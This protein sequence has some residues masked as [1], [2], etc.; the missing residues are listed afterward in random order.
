M[1]EE[2]P[3]FGKDFAIEGR[4]TIVVSKATFNRNAE[5]G[6][7]ALFAAKY[8]IYRRG[9]QLVQPIVDTV[10][11][12]DG[13]MTMT[14]VLAP[15]TVPLMRQWLN[16]VADWVKPDG[17]S[18]RMMPVAPPPEVAEL[19]LHRAGYWPFHSIAGVITTPTMRP[20]GTLLTVPS[21]DEMTRLRLFGGTTM[22]PIP[23]HPT[24]EDAQRAL[25]LLKTL[26]GGFPFVDEVSEAVALSGFITPVVRGVMPVAPMHVASAPKSGTGKSYLWDIASCIAV[27]KP[28]AVIAAGR[29]EAE[30]EKRLVA[31]VLRGQPIVSI[32]NVNGPLEGDFLCQMI[33]RPMLDLRPLGASAMMTVENKITSFATGNNIRGRGDVVRRLVHCRLDANVARPEL[34]EFKT[35]PDQLVLFDRGDYVAACLTI[36][37]AYVVAR[38]PGRLKP[39]PSFERWSDHV[40]SA[41]VWLGCQDPARSMEAAVA[42]DDTEADAVALFAA[43]PHGPAALTSY[44]STELIQEAS[45]LD[46]HGE[47]WPGLLRMP[48]E[49]DRTRPARQ[50]ERHEPRKLAARQQGPGARCIGPGPTEA[51]AEGASHAAVMVRRGQGP[52]N[53][54]GRMGCGGG[55]SHSTLFCRRHFMREGLEQPPQPP[56]PPS[57]EGSTDARTEARAPRGDGRSRQPRSPLSG[58]TLPGA[59]CRLAHVLDAGFC[60]RRHAHAHQPDGPARARRRHQRP[61]RRHSLADHRASQLREETMTDQTMT[62]RW[63][64][65]AE[66]ADAALGRM[67]RLTEARR[68]GKRKEETMTD[69]P[70]SAQW[71]V[72]QDSEAMHLHVALWNGASLTISGWKDD[73]SVPFVALRTTEHGEHDLQDC[74]FKSF[75]AFLD[76]AQGKPARP[77][78]HLRQK[79]PRSRSLAPPR[80]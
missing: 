80:V 16:E 14:V 7:A 56:Q 5:E 45:R 37:R 63:H 13:R 47:L 62:A 50:P 24:I 28:C 66:Y 34:R 31:A 53:V 78:P 6:E 57:F 73:A 76:V 29:D 38:M 48:C 71:R 43:W 52:M 67:L 59:V 64:V 39:I 36:A 54:G 65:P 41:L 10:E 68:R 46:E 17:R 15:A 21:F 79:A 60:L 22:P 61:P 2:H 25:K 44:T 69:R 74:G 1:P 26:L 30:T 8:P 33:E 77:A 3:D 9:N 12:S 58:R 49:A 35:K 55:A 20:D 75:R 4:P 72:E 18:K 32:D 19:I 70:M 42:D 27:G 23:D 40:R 11:A 51:E